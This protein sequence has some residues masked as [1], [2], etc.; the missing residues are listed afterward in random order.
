MEPRAIVGLAAGLLAL[1]AYFPYVINALSGK[2]RPNRAT[3]LIWNILGLVLLG[4]Y[5]SVGATD[6]IWIPL[7]NQ[8]G[9]LAVLLVSLKHGEGGWDG[10]DRW[11]LGGAALGLAS[12]AAFNS[13]LAAL[14]ISI[15]VDLFGAVPTLKK[16]YEDPEHEDR[17]AWIIFLAANTLNLFAVSQWTLG[18]ASYP[19]YLF[20]L[21]LAM[22]IILFRKAYKGRNGV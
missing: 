9:F 22:V 3:W 16:A 2:N 1:T 17:L 8:L 11:C 6:T 5:Y 12:W 7:F 19:V 15:A 18:I 20:F 14:L 13:P 10:I 4:S 21:C